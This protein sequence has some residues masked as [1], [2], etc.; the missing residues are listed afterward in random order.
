MLARRN[1]LQAVLWCVL[2]KRGKKGKRG[3]R[4][5]TKIFGSFTTS[6]TG[7]WKNWTQKLYFE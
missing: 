3:R 6:V 4:T 7:K 5:K 2:S 1:D